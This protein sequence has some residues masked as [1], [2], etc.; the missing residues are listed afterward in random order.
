MPMTQ[1]TALLHPLRR[2]AGR[3]NTSARCTACNHATRD[4]LLRPPSVPREFWVT[5]QMRDGLATW[6]MGR[7]IFAYRMHPHHGRPLSQEQVGN[8]LGLTQ[9]Q[10]SRIEN[11]RAPEELTKLIR[12]AQI[13]GIPGDLLW[14]ALPDQRETTSSER[15]RPASSSHDFG[16]RQWPPGSAAH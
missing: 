1:S 16:H 7:V 4:T 8:W 3:D 11:G 12:Y 13:L 5:D 9:A 6:H 14:F 15:P 10:L 2:S